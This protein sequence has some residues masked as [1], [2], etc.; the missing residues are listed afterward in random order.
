MNFKPLKRTPA[1]LAVVVL[2]LVCVVR[3]LR[4]DFFERLER[5]TYDLRVRAAQKFPAPAAT[6]L[7]FVSV[8]ESSIAAVKSGRLGYSYGLEWPRQVYGRL[9]EE[10]SAQNAK[11]VAFD[12]LFGDL[13]RDHPGVEMANGTVLE[14]DDFFAL[15]MRR[16][17]NTILATTP[18]TVLPELFA[19]N[20]FALG[21]ISS[22]KDS[23]GSFRRVQAF[24]TIRRWHPLLRRFAARPDPDRPEISLDLARARFA[25]GKIIL[26]Q[27]GATNE[28][29]IPVD[30]E[31]NFE[32]ADFFGDKLPPGM[33]PKAKAFTDQRVWHMGIVLAAQVLKLDL[34]GADM[35]L[36]HGRIMLRGANGIERILPV[37][38]DGCFYIDWQLTPNDPR[39]LRAPIES[40]LWQ[41]KLR[42]SDET[43]GL[44]DDFRGKLAVITWV[45]QG[46]NL[47]DEGATPLDKHTL[48]ASVH[49]NVANSVITGRFVRRASLPTE[50]A[51]IVLLGTLTAWLTWQLRVVSASAAILLLLLAYVATVFSAF[52]QYRYW[53]PLVF[54][55]AGAMLFEHVCL[56]TYRVVFEQRE[57]RRVKSVFSK[58]VSPT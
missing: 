31:N 36:P 10:L 17:G 39:L 5:M 49:W 34:H 29:E 43:N 1:L 53:L 55:I 57:Q 25:P 4:F 38:A 35:D 13:R 44:R 6:N 24:C 23:D 2:A 33:A 14:S 58:I 20:A 52:I 21:D 56:V 37:D 50:L 30:K 42:L 15:Q 28:I 47:T 19:T 26:P 45:V 9:V 12:V 7:A 41:D 32:L 48:L 54:P 18:E 3:L 8:E 46:N 51:L 22:V 27:S 40:L 11:A 16:A